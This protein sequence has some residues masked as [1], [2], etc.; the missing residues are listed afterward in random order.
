MTSCATFCGTNISSYAVAELKITCIVKHNNSL[1]QK[2]P[3]EKKS[4]NLHIQK[5]N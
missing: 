5:L 3:K 2:I 1:F 4:A